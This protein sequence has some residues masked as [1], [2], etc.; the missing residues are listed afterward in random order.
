MT[1]GWHRPD[2]PHITIG[3][4]NPQTQQNGT[5]QASHGYTETLQSACVVNVKP[6]G[7]M[8]ADSVKSVWPQGLQQ[9]GVQG[10]P[11]ELGHGFV[12]WSA[13]E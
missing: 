9:E 10:N 2:A 11:A 5:H 8:K 12:S 1:G 6:S 3:V 4:K 7:S 13:S